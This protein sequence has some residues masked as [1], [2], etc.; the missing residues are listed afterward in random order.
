MP[1][2]AP[3]EGFAPWAVLVA[4]DFGR[5][6]SRLGRALSATQRRELAASMFDGV[7][8]ACVGTSELQGT[9]VATDGRDTA[10]LALRRGARVLRDEPLHSE[11]HAI[12]DRALAHVRELGA[13]H[14]LVVMADLPLARTRDLRELLA[15][16]RQADVV[17]APDAERRGTGALAVRLDLGFRTCFGHADSLQRHL[18][19]AHRLRVTARVLYNPRLAFDLDAP[20]HLPQLER[21]A[22]VTQVAQ[23]TQAPT[24]ADDE[25][26]HPAGAPAR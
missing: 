6:K 19:E 13:T 21:D 7:L 11:L 10:A 17:I 23:A 9:L 18:R 8:G 16:V 20:R 3:E 22:L 14:A 12:V 24:R 26:L 4:K 25:P 15:L 2:A 5:A 1:L